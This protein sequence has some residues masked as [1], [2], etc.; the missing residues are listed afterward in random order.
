MLIPGFF[1]D[2]LFNDFFDMPRSGKTSAAVMNTDVKDGETSYEI[3]IELPGCKKEDVT[4]KLQDGYLTVSATTKS[5]NAK[6]LHRERFYGSCSR[7]YY[8]GEDVEK[9]DISAAFEDGILKITVPKKQPKP[10]I[11][12]DH[13]IA[14]G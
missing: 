8:V 7:S 1:G 9:A 2:T 6:Y 11:E 10:E 4:A 5:E 3:D 12:E 14:I 13:Y